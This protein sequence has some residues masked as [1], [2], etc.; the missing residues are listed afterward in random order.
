MGITIKLNFNNSKSA[1]A[2]TQPQTEVV[3][4]DENKSKTLSQK[5]PELQK[6]TQNVLTPE[7]ETKKDI[8]SD[9]ISEVSSE[10]NEQDKDLAAIHSTFKQALLDMENI[11]E[12]EI[13]P[14]VSLAQL[15]QAAISLKQM[16]NAAPEL[17]MLL[18]PEEIGALANQLRRLADDTLMAKVEAKAAPKTS[19]KKKG[20]PDPTKVKVEHSLADVLF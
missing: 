14:Q 6:Y 20:E 1:P 2:K 13:A 18:A 17:G 3:K 16:L 19:R 12:D 4:S 9:N 15:K 5:Q 10:T 7:T 8:A 11:I